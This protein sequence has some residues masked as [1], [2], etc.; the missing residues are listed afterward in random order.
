[1]IPATPDN[2]ALG[3]VRG[4]CPSVHAPFVELDGA[5]LRVRVPGGVL[6]AV[7]ARGIAEVVARVGGGPIELTN[8]A[9]LQLRGIP[10][11][12]VPIVRDAL[13]AVGVVSR[14]PDADERRNVLGS[15][16]AGVDAD[17]LVDT[18]AVLSSVAD[19]L[20]ASRAAGLSSKFGVL[21]D[22]GGA[23]HVRGRAHDVAL[24]ALRCADGTVRYEVRL[25]EALPLGH[26]NGHPAHAPDEPVW[27]VDPSNVI[28]VVEAAIDLCVPFGRARDLLDAVGPERVWGDLA[29]CTDDALLRC[30]GH[31]VT[32]MQGPSLPPVGVWRQRRAGMVSVGAVPVLGRL[33]AATLGVLADLA[34]GAAAGELRISPWR[35]VVLT[36]IAEAD[37]AKVVAACDNVGLMCDPAHP[38]NLVVA[39]VGNQGCAAGL[40]DAHADART[41]IERL[42]ELPFSQRPRSVHVSGC[43]KGCA[44]PQRTAL[45]LV[46]GPAPGTYDLYVDRPGSS[47]SRFGERLQRGLDS[48][49]AIDAVLAAGVQQ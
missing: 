23:V 15:P 6:S 21:V 30:H 37:A 16:T 46:A 40:A 44:R 49:A 2:P 19:R 24:G 13:V 26:G 32:V 10:V 45:S 12:S 48:S 47:G 1:M 17:E 27:L 11:G 34:E 41:L 33:E 31:E 42:G 8:R 4:E 36:D 25:D 28:D 3:E 35:S 5:L 18:R 43:E 38:A 14:D 20:V 9:N 39:C 7:A 22:G 29:R